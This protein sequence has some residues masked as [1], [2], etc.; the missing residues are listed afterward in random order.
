M[1]QRRTK[2]N[3]VTRVIS[4]APVPA[5][6]RPTSPFSP[7]NFKE[8]GEIFIEASKQPEFRSSST[9]L[10][11][12]GFFVINHSSDDHKAFP[13]PYFEGTVADDD[14]KTNYDG[15][16]LI[17]VA[18]MFQTPKEE[19]VRLVIPGITE[20]SLSRDVNFD[21][22]DKTITGKF[23]KGVVTFMSKDFPRDGYPVFISYH[24]D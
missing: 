15:T 3:E 6:I 10:A 1:Y 2:G 12:L 9:F 13:A 18:K 4:R 23:E 5:S 7:G 20:M 14:S 21:V 11:Q 8:L 17:I 16:N 22:G 19:T 24:H